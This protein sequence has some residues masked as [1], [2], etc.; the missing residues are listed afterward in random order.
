MG[1]LAAEVIEVTFGSVRPGR[2]RRRGLF[3]YILMLRG[4]VLSRAFTGALLACLGL[5]VAVAPGSAAEAAAPADR[6]AAL[7]AF[8]AVSAAGR[9]PSGWTGSV[10][11]CVVGAE[12][13]QSLAATSTAVNTV[14]SFASL[15][16]VTFSPE[17]NQKA[18]P[19]S[20]AAR[21]GAATIR[22]SRVVA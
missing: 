10:N 3:E 5:A 16:E 14:R 15:G 11:G 22:A 21:G 4:R 6:G 17:K 13:P 8:E 12:S 20:V 7:A 1:P 19:L 18:L 9:V 2:G